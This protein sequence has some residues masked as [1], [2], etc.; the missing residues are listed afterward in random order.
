MGDGA[1][2]PSAETNHLWA[3]APLLQG[4]HLQNSLNGEPHQSAG[5]VAV[6][7]RS[8]CAPFFTIEMEPCSLPA[9]GDQDRSRVS[10]SAS[11]GRVCPGSPQ[12]FGQDLEAYGAARNRQP[13]RSV[14]RRA[15]K[16]LGR[17]DGLVVGRSRSNHGSSFKRHDLAPKRGD[18]SSSVSLLP[19]SKEAHAGGPGGVES[20]SFTWI[21]VFAGTMRVRTNPRPPAWRWNDFHLGRGA[22]PIGTPGANA[23]TSRIPRS[24]SPLR[25]GCSDPRTRVGLESAAPSGFLCGLEIP[26][27]V[28]GPW[29]DCVPHEPRFVHG[30]RVP[31]HPST[32]RSAH[33]SRGRER[34]GAVHPR[35]AGRAGL[36]RRKNPKPVAGGGPTRV[37]ESSFARPSKGSPC[38]C[39]FHVERLHGTGLDPTKR[40]GTSFGRNPLGVRSRPT[41]LSNR[42]R[43]FKSQLPIQAIDPPPAAPPSLHPPTGSNSTGPGRPDCQLI[44]RRSNGVR[45]PPA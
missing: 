37:G 11:S 34:A 22:A 3:A 4:R 7:R 27:T 42:P 44:A 30:S 35:A 13:N 2:L 40:G 8:R 1:G 23:C 10:R 12:A 43:W 31:T 39:E 20:G 17:H 36:N 9:S 41:L 6:C 15:P 16:D 28:V 14:F 26:G 19:A 33:A 29:V 45:R 25:P 21:Q 18:S 38:V 32:P 5:R 24:R